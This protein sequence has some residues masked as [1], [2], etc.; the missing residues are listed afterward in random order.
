MHVIE[1]TS[2]W[3]IPVP[4][5]CT[6]ALWKRMVNKDQEYVVVGINHHCRSSFLIHGMCV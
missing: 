5:P 2:A 1:P 4:I 3:W 6:H